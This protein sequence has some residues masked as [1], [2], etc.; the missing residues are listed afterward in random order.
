MT[1]VH[2]TI[3]AILVSSLLAVYAGGQVSKKI[4][5][6]AARHAERANCTARMSEIVTA[7]NAQIQ[8]AVDEARA[9]ADAIERTPDEAAEIEALCNRSASCRSRVGNKGD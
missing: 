9:A 2:W 5:V 3:H 1:W 4:E 6:A 8:A 7:Q